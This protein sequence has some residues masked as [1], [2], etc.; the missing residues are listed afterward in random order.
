MSL[1][2]YPLNPAYGQGVY[3]RRVRL[4]GGGGAVTAVL[5]DDYHSMWCRLS[6]DSVSILSVDGELVRG[7]KTTCPGAVLALRELVGTHLNVSRRSL[8]GEGRT[9]RNCTHLLD[10]AMLAVGHAARGEVERVI[11]IAVP[12]KMDGR[13]RMQ[14]H[15]DGELVHDWA[16]CGTEIENP[17]AFAG[18]SMFSGFA[19]WAEAM[20]DDA[21]LDAA[22]MMQKAAFVARGRV[23]I[24]DQT[25]G[26]LAVDE[27]ERLG[28]CFSFSEPN[29][30]VASDNLGYV[31]DF[32]GGIV[33]ILPD[34]LR[35]SGRGLSNEQTT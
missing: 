30:S 12:D 17:A 7:P 3:R 28:D 21:A 5:N 22:R 11:D 23:R 26:M 27:P 29:F 16:I 20:F 31:R 32:T 35:V 33:E 1:A 6:H 8:Y 14:A 10:L 15:V 13:T 9:S 18:R 4:I 24:V 2:R 34:W 25:A 19:S